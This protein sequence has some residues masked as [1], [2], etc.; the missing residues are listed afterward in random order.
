M[1]GARCVNVWEA[2]LQA[3]APDVADSG[4]GVDY[5]ASGSGSV[6][7]YTY[8]LDNQ[9]STIDYNA[10]NGEITTTIN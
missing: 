10:A 2:L 3:N 4:A 7:T 1:T 6:C 5:L 9:S 8:Q